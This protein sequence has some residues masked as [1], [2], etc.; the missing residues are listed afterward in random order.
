M[1]VSLY[2][3][4]T[5]SH[6]VPFFHQAFKRKRAVAQ[7]STLDEFVL[8]HAGEYLSSFNRYQNKLPAESLVTYRY[9]DVIY[10]KESWLADLVEHLNLPSDRKL[11]REVSDRHDVI[12]KTEN[13]DKHIRQVHPGDYLS[14]LS[15]ATIAQLNESLA[16]FL[17]FYGYK[18]Q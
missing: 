3:S 12:P 4:V 1:L 13:E 18:F 15:P 16:P 2:F 11:L 17:D 10:E 5:K 8:K 9:E 7:Q 6:V 14:K